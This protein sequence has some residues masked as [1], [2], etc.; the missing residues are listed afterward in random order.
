MCAKRLNDHACEQ[1]CVRA[2]L[3]EAAATEDIKAMFRDEQFMARIHA[4][5]NKRLGTEKPILE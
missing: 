2:E 5:A 4:E 3:L 1:N